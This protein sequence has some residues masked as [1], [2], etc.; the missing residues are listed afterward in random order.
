MNDLL[1]PSD[2]K[3]GDPADPSRALGVADSQ[4]PKLPPPPE[5]A[6]VKL[7]VRLFLIPLL[8]AGAVIG[9]MVPFGWLTGGQKS[10]D[11]ALADLRR[12]GGQRT[13]G[14]LVGPGAKQRYIDAKT[15]VD[16]LREGKLDDAA[17]TKLADQIID[18]LDQHTSSDEGEVQ[19]VLLLALGQVWMR[20]RDRA[21]PDQFLPEQDSSQSL[22]S[23][24]R[25]LDTLLKYADDKAVSTRKPAILALAYWKGRDEAQAAIP[26]LIKKLE[27]DSEVDV[28]ISAATAL[29]QITPPDNAAAI[30]AL[31]R[32]MRD[33]DPHNAELVW[34]AAIALAQLN[35][36]EAKDVVL[37]LLDRK[38]LDSLQYY[39]RETDAKNPTMQPLGDLEKERFLINAMLAAKNYSDPD[40]QAAIKK[41]AT[42]D[43]S[44]RVKQAAMEIL[45][46]Q[47][48]A[49]K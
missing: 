48:R 13:G 4:I 3:A 25:V 44:E 5:P 21:H 24:K 9:I 28:R 11:V 20:P 26:L 34:N 2:V 23:R 35:R 42:S 8:I 7:I 22:V 18:I 47:K 33:S 43:P 38:E 41:L 31:G 36:P 32:A 39:D 16:Y 46:K 45:E 30:D 14:W 15:I 37:R 19:A 29:A 12:P 17:R 49:A 6:S 1:M 40:I 27:S 10:I